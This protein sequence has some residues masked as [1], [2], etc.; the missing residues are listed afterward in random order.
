MSSNVERKKIVSV[1]DEET[2]LGF[3]LA[4]IAEAYTVEPE[5]AGRILKKLAE[6][7]DLAILIV[8]EDVAKANTTIIAKIR[9]QTYPVIVE[10]PG[11]KAKYEEEEDRVQEL[12]RMALG[13]D[14]E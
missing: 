2:S 1:G 13:I 3:K 11:K 6:Q 4:G 9:Q 14:I 7:P 12:I 5:N 8:T 10:V